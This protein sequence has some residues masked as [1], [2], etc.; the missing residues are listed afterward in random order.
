MVRIRQHGSQK[1]L[2]DINLF[3]TDIDK[4]FEI[5]EWAIDIAWCLGEGAMEIENDS[6]NGKQLTFLIVL[7]LRQKERQKVK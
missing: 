1:E 7:S 2:Y 5:D 6:N 4:Y 3:L